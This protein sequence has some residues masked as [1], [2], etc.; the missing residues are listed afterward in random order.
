MNNEQFEAADVHTEVSAK[1]QIPRLAELARD[2]SYRMAGLTRIS[3]RT[4]LAM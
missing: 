2:D 3:V 1:V 4:E